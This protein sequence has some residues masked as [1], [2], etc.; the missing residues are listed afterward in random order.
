[1]CVCQSA[2]NKGKTSLK[3]LCEDEA[4]FNEY[5]DTAFDKVDVDK[6]GYL[7]KEEV[8]QLVQDL[9]NKLKKDTNVPEE[10]VKSALELIDTDKDGKV[11]KE[12]FRKTSRAKLL[13]ICS[14]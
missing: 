1:M 8:R 12:E 9:V 13:A 14:S 3:G 11:T 2:V 5:M 4:K 7:E 10:K 6:N